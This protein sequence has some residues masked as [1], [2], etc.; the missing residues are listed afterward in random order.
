MGDPTSLTP[1]LPASLDFHQVV[2]GSEA[3]K[4]TCA[5]RNEVLRKPLGLDLFSED[6]SQEK[7]QLHFGMFDREAKLIACVI[8]VPQA[9]DAAKIRQMAV[10]AGFTGQGV[11]RMLMRSLEETLAT[12]GVV[13]LSLHAR[14]TAAGFY[15]K[16]GYVRTGEPF[17]EV[18][19]PHIRMEKSADIE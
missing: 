16:L 12:R 15:E 6:L 4:Q 1:I 11:G 19:I 5:L 9:A 10:R 3:Y 18:G 8:A 13:K 14:V 7:D 17:V 2:F